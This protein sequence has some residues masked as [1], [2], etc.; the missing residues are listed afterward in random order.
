MSASRY[1]TTTHVIAFEE[2]NLVG[3]VYYVNHLR[4]QGRCRELFLKEHAPGVL[5]ELAL[6]LALVTTHASCDYLEELAAFDTVEIRMRLVEENQNRLTLGFETWRVAP[7]A[8]VLAA[9]GRQQIASMRKE[10]D[11]YRPAPLP[12]ELKRALDPYRSAR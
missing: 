12:A 4:W 9:R 6:G 2:T 7:G 3:N 8:P 11:A 1:F 10:G 5:K